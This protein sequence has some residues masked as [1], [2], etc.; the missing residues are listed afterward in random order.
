MASHSEYVRPPKGRFHLAG[1]TF[2]RV[3][4]WKDRNMRILYFY[5]LALILTNTANG[6]E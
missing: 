6:F 5:M 2:P 4:W 3:K 1:K